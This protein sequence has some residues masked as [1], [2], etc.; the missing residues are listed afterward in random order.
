[1]VKVA[2]RSAE[3][4]GTKGGAGKAPTEEAKVV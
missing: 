3:I 4:V 1:M 2:S